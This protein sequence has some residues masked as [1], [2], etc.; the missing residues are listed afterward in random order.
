MVLSVVLCVLVVSMVVVQ[1][2]EEKQLV[3]VIVLFRH[4]D[5]SPIKAYPTDPYQEKDW[6]QGFGQLSRAGMKQHL[7]LGTYLRSRY[8]NF[9]NESYHRS[10]ISVRSTDVDRTLMSAEANLAGLYP[11]SGHQIFAPNLTWQ[12]IPVH[13][14]PAH[15]DK[16][17]LFPLNGC[18]RYEQLMKETAQSPEFLN[19]TKKYQALIELVSNR[20]GLNNTDVNSIWSVYDTLFCESK[21]NMTPPDWVTADVW[22]GLRELKDF[23]LQVNFGLHKQQEKSRLQGGLLLGFVVQRLTNMSA[24]DQDEPLKMTML[25]AHDTT[26]MALQFSMNVSNGLQPPYASCHI[27]E[28]YRDQK[29]NTSVQMFFRNDSTVP[30]YPVQLPGCALDCPLLD[31]TRITKASISEDRDKECEVVSAGQEREVVIGLVASGCVLFLLIA[32]LL[33]LICWQREPSSSGRGYRHVTSGE[34][35]SES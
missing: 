20:T 29:G 27:F 21:H 10:E 11:P 16:L 2:A 35:G 34:D 24:A 4:G 12:P 18:A 28:L 9:L 19:I 8:K 17:L 6:P 3:H 7:E 30:P 23:S 1:A 25:S 26:V 14:V 33:G 5:R 13:T 31:F 32:L 22:K 15:Q